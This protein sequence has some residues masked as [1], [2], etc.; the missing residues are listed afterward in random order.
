MLI[1]IAGLAVTRTTRFALQTKAILKLPLFCAG[2]PWRR[3][4][5]D[6]RLLTPF[7]PGDQV[8]VEYD[9]LQPFTGRVDG[10]TPDSIAVSGR[11]ADIPGT[12]RLGPHVRRYILVFG[13]RY[14]ST[15]NPGLHVVIRKVG[16]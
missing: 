14:R 10:V 16:A 13:N 1:G 3:E 11:S 6:T 4:M 2:W 9:D 8:T 7:R 5:P 15:A 12:L